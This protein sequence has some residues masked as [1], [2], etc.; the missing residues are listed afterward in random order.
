MA[1]GLLAGTNK[2]VSEIYLHCGFNS[3]SYFNRVFKKQYGV[4][5]NCYRKN[6]M[7]D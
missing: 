3:L 2:K 7:A 5:P 6:L 1:A 4:S